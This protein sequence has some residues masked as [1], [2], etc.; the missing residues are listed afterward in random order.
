MFL[1]SISVAL[2]TNANRWFL[3]VNNVT[4]HLTYVAWCA[5]RDNRRSW[6]LFAWLSL[7]NQCFLL[8]ILLQYLFCDCS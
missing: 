6:W 8:R 5:R 2:G 4:V 3:N 7:R 1:A